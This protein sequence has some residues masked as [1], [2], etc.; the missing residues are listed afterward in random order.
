MIYAG[1]KGVVYLFVEGIYSL[2]QSSVFFL[3]SLFQ[4]YSF[5]THALPIQSSC[6]D[7]YAMNWLSGATPVTDTSSYP[8]E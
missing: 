1:L 8:R 4:A 6:D 5:S 3:A 7:S 2:V